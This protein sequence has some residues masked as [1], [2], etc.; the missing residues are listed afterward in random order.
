MRHFMLFTVLAS[1]IL[2]H[3][4]YAFGD[5]PLASCKSNNGTITE[6]SGINTEHAL[7]KGMITKADIQEYCERDPGGSTVAY[8]GK[9]TIAQCVNS[10]FQRV[11]KDEMFALANCKTGHLKFRYGTSPEK[12]VKFPLHRDADTSCASGMPPMIQ[13]FQ[14][15]C[16]AAAAKW[17]VQ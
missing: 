3:T 10:M 12:A 14:L 16:P 8:G 4:A 13:Q 5:F 6:R 1:A 15:L 9:L 7:I 11:A 17:K 2:N